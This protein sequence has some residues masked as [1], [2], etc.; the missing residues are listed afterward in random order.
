MLR[1]M[2]GPAK[3]QRKVV[4]TDQLHYWRSHTIWLCI[5][6]FSSE[7][8]KAALKGKLGPRHA[9]KF[10]KGA[11]HQI[12]IR[13]RKGPSPGITQKCDSHERGP[14]AS[15]FGE[16]SY[17]GIA[18]QERCA[19]GILWVL[20]ETCDTPNPRMLTRSILFC[21]AKEKRHRVHEIDVSSEVVLIFNETTLHAMATA[22]NRLAKGKQSKW[23]FRN[24]GERKTGED[25][26][27]SEG[28][29]KGVKEAKRF[30]H[31]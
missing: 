3:S 28:K 1:L 19:S 7:K 21:L 17:Q 20:Q 12:K 13:E 10:P 24:E 27:K 23:W 16:R 6:R 25:K 5:S 4:R 22:S 26:G 30:E 9:V 18:H 31:K 15:K 8:I 2:K 14:C 29:S 11:W